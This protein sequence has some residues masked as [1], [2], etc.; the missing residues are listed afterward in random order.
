M[1]TVNQIALGPYK[2]SILL[3]YVIINKKEGKIM[4]SKI[5]ASRS[6]KKMNKYLMKKYLKTKQ[7]LIQDKALLEVKDPFQKEDIS[8][9]DIYS[10]H[11]TN[12]HVIYIKG[13]DFLFPGNMA[14]LTFLKRMHERTGVSVYYIDYHN[15]DDLVDKLS[16]TINN[17]MDKYKGIYY[18]FGDGVISNALLKVTSES[19]NI[20]GLCLIS[21]AFSLDITT[22]MDDFPFFSEEDLKTKMT[23]LFPMQVKTNVRI[24]SGSLDI[25]HEQALDYAKNHIKVDLLVI[26]GASHLAALFPYVKDQN[27]VFL[28]L[29]DWLTNEKHKIDTLE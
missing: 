3:F 7:F 26:E 24:I 14:R 29:S 9:L 19:D 11:G 21:P 20:G 18:L 12:K 5:K 13:H 25:L 8:P 1:T 28:W 22:K 16:I 2:K 6:L 17:I 10:I 15:E 27:N 23:Y 4:T